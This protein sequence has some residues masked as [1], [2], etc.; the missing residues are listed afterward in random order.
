YYSRATG[1]PFIQLAT[2]P[3][4]ALVRQLI[5]V[6]NAAASFANPFGPDLTFPQF[7]AYSPTPTRSITI[8]DQRYGPPVSQECSLNK[9]TGLG[10]DSLIEIGYV[11][12]HGNSKILAHTLN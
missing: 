1:Q 6:P 11:G 7:P 2:S 10:R 3:P 5:G 12:A 4:F 9:Q 8:V